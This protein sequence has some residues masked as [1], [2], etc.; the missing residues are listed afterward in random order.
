M[1]KVGS[2]QCGLLAMHY[3]EEDI[4]R[5]LGQGRA[6]AGYPQPHLV[7]DKLQ[8]VIKAVSPKYNQLLEYSDK[9]HDVEA[10][11]LA[12]VK[13]QEETEAFHKSQQEVQDMEEQALYKFMFCGAARCTGK[14]AC[15]I[16]LH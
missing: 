11:Y 4:R 13:G 12:M 3:L 16:P 5:F 10:G 7:Q 15:S 2:L 14:G 9:Y 6:A 8:A 1:Q